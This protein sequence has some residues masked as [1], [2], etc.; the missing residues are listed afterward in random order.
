MKVLVVYAHPDSASF[1]HAVLDEVLAG[2]QSA[3]HE[4][5]VRDLYAEGFEPRLSREEKRAHLSPPESKPQLAEHFADLRW[6]D[7]LVLVHPTWWGAQP[8][9][10]KGWIDRVWAR[11]VAW[12][13]PDGAKRLKPIL[14]N[15]RRIITFTTHGSPWRINA[16]QGVP[17]RRI[18]NR[19]LR[20][21][22]HPLCRTRWI[23]M[24]GIDASTPEQRARHL[25]R[26]RRVASRL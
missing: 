11:G 23:A 13:L 3:R 2:L 18:A 6:C 10:L 9:M 14:H 7:A 16:L 1:N 25:R 8:A 15:V 20:V 21:I 5:R 12:E 26:V 4:V 19:S 24:Y 17:G 22:C